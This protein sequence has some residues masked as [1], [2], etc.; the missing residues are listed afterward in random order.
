MRASELI[1]RLQDLVADVGDVPVRLDTNPLALVGIDYVEIDCEEDLIVISAESVDEAELLE[2][3]EMD[4]R[5]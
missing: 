3:G 1:A 4:A 2:L 5:G